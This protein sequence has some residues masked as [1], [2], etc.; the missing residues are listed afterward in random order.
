MG[1][2]EQYQEL[3]SA[4]KERL[5]SMA[6]ELFCEVRRPEDVVECG[7]IDGEYNALIWVLD[8]M[9]VDHDYEQ[10]D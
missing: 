5:D 3:E 10:Q 1:L 6:E 2:K 8:L 7:R 4:I 9:G